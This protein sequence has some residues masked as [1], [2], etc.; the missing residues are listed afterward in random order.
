MAANCTLF[1]PEAPLGSA[2]ARGIRR[3][4]ASRWEL[5]PADTWSRTDGPWRCALDADR[6][7]GR[8]LRRCSS[9]RPL[10]PFAKG[11]M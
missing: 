5:H 8:T 11:Q 10:R 6:R 2:L 4:R 1:A 3:A 7:R 9:T